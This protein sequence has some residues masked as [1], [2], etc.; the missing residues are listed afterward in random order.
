MPAKDGTLSRSEVD[1]GRPEGTH[2]VLVGVRLLLSR[3]PTLQQRT[4]SCSH[5]VP[6]GAGLRAAS[7]RHDV[8]LLR[9]EAVVP[10]TIVPQALKQALR[11]I[12]AKAA[13]EMNVSSH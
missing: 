1:G 10:P 7:W 5:V 11:V 9:V 2:P 8:M 3:P 4:Q 12:P 6:M 13:D